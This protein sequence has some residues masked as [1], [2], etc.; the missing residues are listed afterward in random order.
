M[1]SHRISWLRAW[2]PSRAW[3]GEQPQRHDPETGV[4]PRSARSA[5]NVIAFY[6]HGMSLRDITRALKRLYGVD[7]SPT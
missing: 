5:R 7:V 3:F 6:P 2:R 1:T 4:D